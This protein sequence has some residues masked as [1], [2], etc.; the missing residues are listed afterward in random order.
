MT[1]REKQSKFLIMDAKLVLRAHEIK[2]PLV[3]LEWMRTKEQQKELV[4]RGLSKT[5]ASKHLDGLAKDYCFLADL[6]DDGKL[7]YPPEKYRVL[8][9]FWESLGG[10]WG[11]R[12]GG[13]R[14]TGKL[15]WDAGHF[16]WGQK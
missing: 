8:G 15:G 2:T 13:N 12:F 3:C 4:S 7:N 11:G 10:R 1:L 6:L 14:R 9:E 5:M 16:E